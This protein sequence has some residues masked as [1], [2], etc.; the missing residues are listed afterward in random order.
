[1]FSIF[2]VLSFFL[3]NTLA[4]TE[5]SNLSESFYLANLFY[6]NN[7]YDQAINEYNKILSQGF[8]NGNLYYNLGNSYF[9][10]GMLGKAILNYEKARLFMPNDGDLKSNYDYVLSLLDL[11]RQDF[12]GNWF[13][14]WINRLFEAFNINSLSL[15]LSFLYTAFFAVLVLRVFF[16]YIKRFDIL[17]GCIVIIPFVLG[18]ISINKKIEYLNKGAIIIRK[19][20]AAKFEPFEKATNHFTLT[21]GSRVEIIDSTVGWYKIKRT[22]GKLGWANKTD[23]EPI[24]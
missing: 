8:E 10:M 2:F 3:S 1:M 24:K 7:E 6:K 5:K 12:P 20:T 18:I 23:V 19:E 15:F 22:D 16:D 14:K 21:E 11:R 9:K 13:L 4:D 17:L